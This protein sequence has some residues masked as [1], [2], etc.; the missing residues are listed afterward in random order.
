MCFAGI[1]HEYFERWTDPASGFSRGLQATKRW[2]T[3]LG[4]WGASAGAAA[5]LVRN[6]SI[7]LGVYSNEIYYMRKAAVRHSPRQTRGAREDPPRA[8][9]PLIVL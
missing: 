2:S 5:F 6:T 8:Y 3:S 1:G 4:F 7:Q 9:T